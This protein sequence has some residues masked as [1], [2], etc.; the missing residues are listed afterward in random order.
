M[1]V[2]NIICIKGRESKK[3]DNCDLNLIIFWQKNHLILIAIKTTVHPGYP[4]LRGH[5][6]AVV[7]AWL[8]E[9][10]DCDHELLDVKL[11]Q[12]QF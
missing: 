6:T 11:W 10:S 3:T 12:A 4:G 1:F 5:K 9:S 8:N 2:I 7:V